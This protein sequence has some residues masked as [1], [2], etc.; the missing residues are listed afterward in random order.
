MRTVAVI[1][2]AGH[3]TRMHSK[4]P[5]ALFPL[6][7]QPIIR[8]VVEAA[9]QATGSK[10]ILVLGRD[11]DE[12]KQAIGAAADYAIQG[13]RLGTGD[14]LRQTEDLLRGH[15]D[16][17]LVLAGDMPLLSP[18]TLK[19]LVE[20]HAERQARQPDLLLPITMLTVYSRDSR[21]YGRV[22]RNAQG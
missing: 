15:S 9:S 11:E 2:A 5:K 3:E 14:A 10:P 19:A 20:K 18:E 1:L 4:T 6:L 7:G 12:V 17:I 16:R 8:Y 13:S 22:L 21:G